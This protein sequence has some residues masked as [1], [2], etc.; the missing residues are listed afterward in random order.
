V[1]AALASVALVIL[2]AIYAVP[3]GTI[4]AGSQVPADVPA[5]TAGEAYFDKPDTIVVTLRSDKSIYVGPNA[6]RRS[7]LESHLRI[8]RGKYP[9]R[10]L[11]LRAFKAATLGDIAPVLGAMRGAGYSQFWVFGRRSAVLELASRTGT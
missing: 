3:F 10:M 6:V 8:M 2:F 7:D 1:A 4:S 11:E 9:D 5:I